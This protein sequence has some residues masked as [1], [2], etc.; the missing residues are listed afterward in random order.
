MFTHMYLMRKYILDG[1][2]THT[3]GGFTETEGGCT[4]LLEYARISSALNLHVHH[5][6]QTIAFLIE[7]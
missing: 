7:K 2:F 5:I 1:D 3:E 6:L 4:R